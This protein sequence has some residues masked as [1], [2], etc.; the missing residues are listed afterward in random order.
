MANSWIW[1]LI[2]ILQLVY[3]YNLSLSKDEN[4]KKKTKH[5]KTK[6]N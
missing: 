2:M 4:L 5:K 6:Q 3:R 1:K